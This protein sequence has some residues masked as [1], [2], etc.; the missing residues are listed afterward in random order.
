M[1]DI[2]A[3]KRFALL[4]ATPSDALAEVDATLRFL[5]ARRD[6]LQGQLVA[7]F[8]GQHDG[9]TLGIQSSDRIIKDRPQ[10]IVQRISVNQVVSGPKQREQAITRS[11]LGV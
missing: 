7:I 2:T 8:I 3:Q 4:I 9:P 1:A 6:G 11:W 5:V 10:K